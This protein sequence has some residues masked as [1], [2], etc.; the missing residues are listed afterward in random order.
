MHEIL[1]ILSRT[2]EMQISRNLAVFLTTGYSGQPISQ[3]FEYSNIFL[4]FNFCLNGFNYSNIINI[5]T[6]FRYLKMSKIPGSWLLSAL[7]LLQYFLFHVNSFR[8]LGVLPTNSKSHYKVGNSLMRGLADAGH[9]V[10]VISPYVP[11][12]PIK[13]YRAIQVEDSDL[14]WPG[15][16]FKTFNSFCQ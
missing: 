16:L 6:C 4:V 3:S 11:E 14:H 5:Y 10:T 8:I 13:N 9:N 1:Q 7:L 12:K 2:V 15:K